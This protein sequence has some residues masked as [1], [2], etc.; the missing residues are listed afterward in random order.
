MSKISKAYSIQMSYEVSDV[1][2]NQA[3]KAIDCLNYAD[4][5]LDKSSDYL[6][7]MKTP[8]KKNSDIPPEEIFKYRAALRRFRDKV[9]NNFNDFKK[10]SFKCVKLLNNFASD[11]QVTKLLKSFVIS[12]ESLQE[13]VNSYINLF[14]DLKDPEF[15]KKIVSNIEEIQKQ[16]IDVQKIINERLINH[17]KENILASSWVDSIGKELEMKIEKKKPLLLELSNKREEQL[18]DIINERK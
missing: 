9:V 4:K 1:E 15:A 8:F 10:T 12:I 14:D 3:E 11:T 16:C 7:L 6:N 17:I 2:K 5:S 18:N 13:K